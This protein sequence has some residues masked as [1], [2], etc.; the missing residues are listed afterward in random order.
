MKP[1]C[2]F[3]GCFMSCIFNMFSLNF[4]SLRSD[5]KTLIEALGSKEI[6]NMKFRSSWAF[7]AAKGFKLP[8]DIEREKVRLILFSLC[9][10]LYI[11]YNLQ[12]Q[13]SWSIC[14][15]CSLFSKPQLYKSSSLMCHHSLL[16]IWATYTTGFYHSSIKSCWDFFFCRQISEM[17]D[18]SNSLSFGM[19]NLTCCIESCIFF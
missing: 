13:I 6:Q 11:M 8:D 18:D 5:A 2:S 1:L 15:N 14:L 10:C 19:S 16:L 12:V 7:I 4:P 17:T 3:S 9:I